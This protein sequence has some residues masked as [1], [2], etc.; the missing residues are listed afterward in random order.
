[1]SRSTERRQQIQQLEALLQEYKYAN[2]VLT[3]KNDALGWDSSALG[4][5]RTR[6]ALLT[7]IEEPCREVLSAQHGTPQITQFPSSVSN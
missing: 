5:S 1:M 4:H 7:E 3:A 2:E 6:E